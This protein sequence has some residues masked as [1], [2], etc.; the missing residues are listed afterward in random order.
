MVL[1]TVTLVLASAQAGNIKTIASTIPSNGEVN[2]YG[3]ALV[4]TTTGSLTQGKW[5]HLEIVIS[6]SPSN[7]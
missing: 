7:P 3:V 4:P 6:N 1:F 2:P 5:L